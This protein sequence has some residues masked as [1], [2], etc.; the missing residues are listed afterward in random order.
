MH[1]VAQLHFR[2]YPALTL[3][4]EPEPTPRI[5]VRQIARR[6]NVSHTTVSRALKDDPRI[7]VAVRKKI[8]GAAET[9]GYRPDPMLSALAAYRKG[10]TKKSIGAELAWIN[11]W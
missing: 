4:M 8:R 7:S 6:L 5:T 11:C 3:K 2:H 10:Q 1:L 9:L